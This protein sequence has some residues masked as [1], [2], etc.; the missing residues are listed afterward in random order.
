MTFR[1]RLWN[2]L[3]AGFWFVAP[4]VWAVLTTLAS[5]IIFL[6]MVLLYVIKIAET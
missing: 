4:V 2:R 1:S 6:V 3:K 5:I